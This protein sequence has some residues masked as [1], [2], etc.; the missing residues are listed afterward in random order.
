MIKP[1]A[2]SFYL[3]SDKLMCRQKGLI[4]LNNLPV[5][6]KKRQAL[7]HCASGVIDI[8]ALVILSRLQII[9]VPC[10]SILILIFQNIT[11]GYFACLQK[12]QNFVSKR[13]D[14]SRKI[15]SGELSHQAK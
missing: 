7:E 14:Y 12:C 10:S 8:F 15:F 4:K 9:F 3:F 5:A 6:G 11:I 13:V 1:G 2:R